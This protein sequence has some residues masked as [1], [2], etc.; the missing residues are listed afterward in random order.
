MA[1]IHET[2]RARPVVPAPEPR[3]VK[4]PIEVNGVRYPAGITLL[5]SAYLLHHDPEL[6]PDPYTFSPE[7]FVGRTP[8]TYTWIP[9]GG[10]RRRCLGA[11]FAL[12]EMKIVLRS[13]LARFELAPAD[14]APERVARRSITF[15]PA[16]GATVILRE[17]ARAPMTTAPGEI[18]AAA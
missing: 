2:L 10:G 13:V 7:R 11:S 12:Q 16:D 5:V 15:S 1:T 8:G 17:R 14:S 3:L 9:F 4:E 6:Y 18:A